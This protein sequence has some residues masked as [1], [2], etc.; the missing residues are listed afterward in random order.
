MDRWKDNLKN[1]MDKFPSDI[2]DSDLIDE[3]GIGLDD[4]GKWAF[5]YYNEDNE[6]I[7]YNRN[8]FNSKGLKAQ[9]YPSNQIDKISDDKD[10]YLCEG[11][12]DEIPLK[13]LKLQAFAGNCGCGTIPKD[14]D[15]NYDLQW[16]KN[17]K[18]TIY[19]CYD[20]ID[21]VAGAKT[22]ADA[23]LEVNPIL[24]VKII[25]WD[26]SLP[27]GFDVYDAFIKDSEASEFFKAKENAIT[28]KGKRKGFKM[29]N[30][31]EFLKQ[32]YPTTEPIIEYMFNKGQTA[33]IG[34]VT[35]SKK[36]MCA[37]QSALSIVSGVPLFDYFKVKKQKVM[38][39][40]FEMENNDVQDRTETMIKHFVQETGTD[41]WL[42]DLTII[43][44]NKN[45]EEFVDN[46]IRIDDTLRE[47]NF[48]D[49]VVI[50]DNIYTSCDKNIQENDEAK[51]L[52]KDINKVRRKFNVSILCI[53]HTNKVTSVLGRLYIDQIQ[54]G[55][56][57]CSNIASVT[58]I[59]KSELSNELGLMKIVKGGRS[60]K[61]NLE[62]LA[63][64]L[65]W[66]DD[67]CTFSKGAIVKNES[68]HFK[69]MKDSYDI[70]LLRE[71]SVKYDIQYNTYFSRDMF[72]RNLP[73]D[74]YNNF[75]KDGEWVDTSISR[76]LKKM[77]DYG[78]IKKVG[79]NKYK[80]IRN[81]LEDF[82]GK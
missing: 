2:W 68:L 39:I 1:N 38:I 35:G 61:N 30:A 55:A 63:F 17:N 6:C 24:D 79:H 7:G 51:L 27:K 48:S 33:I 44:V 54:G 3:I 71:L 41:K 66:S 46:W 9:W 23:I 57:L 52:V 15:G 5:G 22:L 19:I 47:H 60:G 45:D 14:K 11:E 82:R 10:V 37:I 77:C 75:K 43:E 53:A 62:N 4:D 73:E 18:K 42:D 26:K 50:V 67:T 8:K 20:A 65:H 13:S 34:G 74:N 69:Q 56:V 16:L 64:K 25:Q 40:Q 72:K 59:G 29:L 81:A 21:S 70:K 78:L 80:L 32:K 31:R 12:K 28:I 36:S 49:G 76:Y 58:M